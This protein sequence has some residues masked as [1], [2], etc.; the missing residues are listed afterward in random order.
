MRAR[1]RLEEQKEKDLEKKRE[2]KRKYLVG[3]MVVHF[4]KRSPEYEKEIIAQLD[5][6]LTRD[7]D[8]KYFGLATKNQK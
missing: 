7:F 1:A 6:F 4:M 5:K 2:D 3:A 8:R